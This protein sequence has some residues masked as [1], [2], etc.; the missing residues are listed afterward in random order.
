MPHIPS[1]LQHNF[2]WKFVDVIQ[3]TKHQILQEYKNKKYGTHTSD[4]GNQ[5]ELHPDN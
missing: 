2:Y 5:Q 4:E 1:I 3:K